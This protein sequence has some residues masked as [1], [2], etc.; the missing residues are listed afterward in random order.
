MSDSLIDPASAEGLAVALSNI[1]TMSQRLRKLYDDAAAMLRQQAAAEE[2]AKVAF[3]EVVQQKKDAQAECERLRGLLGAAYAD[4]RRLN[5]TH[6]VRH[7][8]A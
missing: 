2:G 5:G 7:E 6:G 4:I 1:P 3:E 8:D